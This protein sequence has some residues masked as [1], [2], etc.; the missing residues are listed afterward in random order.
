[1]RQAKS[2]TEKAKTT[3]AFDVCK[4]ALDVHIRVDG[5]AF[6]VPN[7]YE[8]FDQVALVLADYDVSLVLMESTGGYEDAVAC[9]FQSV[10]Y[11]VAV[12]NPRHGRNFAM[13]MGKFAK[14]DRIDAAILADFAAVIDTRPDR[15]RFIKPPTDEER[16]F[17]SQMVARR[18]QVVDLL[19]TEKQ[20]LSHADDYAKQSINKVVAFIESQ[21]VEINKDVSFYLKKNYSGLSKMLSEIPGIGELSVGLLV[22]DVPEL[23]QIGNR[24][25]SAVIGV[26]PFNHDSGKMRG[27]RCISGGRQNVRNV[28]FMG[29]MSATRYNPV[30]KAFYD[31][32]INKGKPKRVAY[33][34]CVH[35]LLRIINAMVRDG[36]SFN[37]DLHAAI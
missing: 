9:Y 37:P 6:Q 32:L 8:G 12:I 26:A 31:R 20:R 10:G 19:S 14:T 28:L 2:L 1:M 29:V 4:A 30:I 13:A 7:T 35:K 33:I 36:T 15:A 3:V 22:G 27:K 11:D 34:A 16:K 17:L 23:G 5:K 18:R 21:L 25:L 24:Q